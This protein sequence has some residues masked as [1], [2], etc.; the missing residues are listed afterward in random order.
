[1]IK[2]AISLY[3]GSK[4]EFISKPTVGGLN[5]ISLVIESGEKKYILRIY[6]NGFDSFRVQFEH[7][8]LNQLNQFDLSFKIPVP[9]L[10]IQNKKSFE[11]L[12]NGYEASMFHYIDG[13]LPGLNFTKEIGFKIKKKKIKKKLKKKL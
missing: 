6:K 5:N 9:L 3:L 1:M 2:E 4:V 13:E 7:E 10:S 12:K 11:K 8:I